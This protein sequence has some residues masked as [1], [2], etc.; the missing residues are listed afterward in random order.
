MPVVATVHTGEKGGGGFIKLLSRPVTHNFITLVAHYIN[1]ATLI[2]VNSLPI[3]R[4]IVILTR[5][6]API[7]LCLTIEIAHQGTDISRPL[8]M[9][10]WIGDRANNDRRQ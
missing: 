3:Q 5:K 7:T 8:L 6:D 10:R 4:R 1:R 2:P 9:Q